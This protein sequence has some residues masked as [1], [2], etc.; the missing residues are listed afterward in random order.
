MSMRG[1]S[2]TSCRSAQRYRLTWCAGVVVGVVVVVVVGVGVVGRVVGRWSLVVA[3]SN[4]DVGRKQEDPHPP[5]GGGCLAWR[6]GHSAHLPASASTHALTAAVA[7]VHL[8]WGMSW[9]TLHRLASPAFLHPCASICIDLLMTWNYP[10][11][12]TVNLTAARS[13]QLGLCPTEPCF[14]SLNVV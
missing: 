3:V 5:S 6:R 8:G 13:G 4:V 7:T 2:V 1:E 11:S 12:Y 9:Q 10:H 14:R